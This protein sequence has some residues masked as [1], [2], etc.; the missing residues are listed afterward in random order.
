MKLRKLL[1]LFAGASLFFVGP[2]AMADD[3]DDDSDGAPEMQVMVD[4]KS[5]EILEAEDDSGD[6]ATASAADQARTVLSGGLSSVV[7]ASSGPRQ[8]NADGSSFAQ[9]GREHFKYIFVTV[10][11]NGETSIKHLSREQ[12]AEENLVTPAGKEEQ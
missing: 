11:E 12:L 7:P 2:V 8:Y 10:D 3:D 1:A 5:G 6:A 4:E 9:V